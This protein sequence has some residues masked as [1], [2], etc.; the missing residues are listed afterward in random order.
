MPKPIESDFEQDW[1][2]VVLF[3][4]LVDVGLPP[5]A[6]GQ[7]QWKALAALTGWSRERCVAAFEEAERKGMIDHAGSSDGQSA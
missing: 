6:S 3:L 1:E 4:M 5:W 7:G 2:K